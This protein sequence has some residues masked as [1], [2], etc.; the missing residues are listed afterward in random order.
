MIHQAILTNGEWHD[1]NFPVSSFKAV[2][3]ISGQQTGESFPVSSFLDL[4]KMLQANEAQRS[5]IEDVSFAQRAEFLKKIAD[6]IE[7][8]ADELVAVAHQE[9]GLNEGWLK[10]SDLSRTT[11]QLRSAADFCN[12]RG[13]RQTIID[14]ENNV[15]TIRVGL[16]GP[17]VIFGPSNRPFSMNACGG[18]DFACAI[19]A[20][21]SIIAKANPNHPATSQMLA[22]IIHTV[23]VENGLPECIFQF[24]FNTTNDLGFR[25][26]AHP[27]L[28]ALAFTGS[29]RSGLAL[30]ENTDRSGNM[31]FFN[32]S[33]FNLAFLLKEAVKKDKVR[34]SQL[35]CDSVLTNNGQSCNKPGIFFLLEDKD[36]SQLIK[37]VTEGFN[38][39]T[40]GPL[41]TDIIAR[42]LDTMVSN[43][44][45]LGAR[46]LTRKEFYQ[47]TPFIY[48]NTVLHLDAKTYLK[49]AAQFNVEATGPVV[50][51]VTLENEN[52]L[53]QATKAIDGCS[54]AGIFCEHGTADDK[55]LNLFF[56]LLARKT[57]CISF[58]RFS[59]DGL[60][61]MAISH[62]GPFPASS[63]PGMPSQVMPLAIQRFTM[64]Q[65]FVS[66]PEHLL[67]EDLK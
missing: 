31:G 11:R 66:C 49:S 8:Q 44:V 55:P 42:K 37:S 67:P 40:A 9:T 62:S 15:K 2:S 35:I 36:S 39:R 57:S 10:E 47:P 51:F 52:Q 63:N 53:G 43:F 14:K 45:R 64:T 24:F 38:S 41:T 30:K 1:A 65:S 22:K 58:N 28:G 33:G 17:V 6:R 50:I 16:P 26:A 7:I 21:N 4:D 23:V 27:M 54:S 13:W 18:I 19:A 59:E 29:L 46:K 20:G 3:P 12:D 5:S 61:S 32:F 34:L 60:A 25:L 48:P 56:S